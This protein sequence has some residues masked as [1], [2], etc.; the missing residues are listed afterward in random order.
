MIIGKLTPSVFKEALRLLPSYKAPG[1]DNISGML[2]KHMPQAFHDAVF[3]LFQ[4]MAITGITPPNW[5]HSNTILL[6]GKNDPLDLTNY[7]PIA[8]AFAL[9]K[10][11]TS[12]LS[13][14]ASDFVEAHK[15]LSP[16]Q[17]GFKAH[18]SAQE[19]SPT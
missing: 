1:P 11:W 8:L 7:R 19:P 6:Y 17:E 10:L 9:C 18:R 15:S 2:I 4:T 3:Q 16:E 13:I 12:C 14:I 5:L